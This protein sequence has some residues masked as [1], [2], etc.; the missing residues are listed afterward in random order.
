MRSFRQKMDFV[1]KNQKT[2]Q[3][4]YQ[5]ASPPSLSETV[6]EIENL[7]RKHAAGNLDDRQ[8]YLA[9]KLDLFR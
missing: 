5:L 7:K 9:A 4:H 3:K 2:I 6:A 1:T 8:H